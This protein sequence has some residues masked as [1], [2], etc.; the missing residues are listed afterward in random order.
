MADI[1]FAA[2]ADAQARAGV[3]DLDTLHARRRTLVN[4]HAA[5]LAESRNKSLVD[6]RRK[7]LL[8]LCALEV[9]DEMDAQ[10]AK[11]TEAKIDACAHTHPRYRAWLDEQFIR[12]AKA[13]VVENELQEIEDT[14]YRGNHVMRMH[15]TEATLR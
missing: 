8:A 1:V 4:D 15:T 10:G 7:E 14:V 12:Q 2:F 11:Y 13:L 3:P 9:R 5:L 6:A